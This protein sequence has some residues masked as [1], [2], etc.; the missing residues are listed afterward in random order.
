G[1]RQRGLDGTRVA[2]G[3]PDLRTGRVTDSLARRADDPLPLAGLEAGPLLKSV[4]PGLAVSAR[5]PRRNTPRDQRRFDRDR[6]GTAEWVEQGTGGRPAA[7]EEH[8]RAERLP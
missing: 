1:V 4:G 6:A 8:R 7:G 3:A 5:Q 2:V